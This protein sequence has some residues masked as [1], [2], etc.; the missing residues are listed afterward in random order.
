LIKKLAIA[1][2]SVTFS[3][4]S[5]AADQ[6]MD[7]MNT[8]AVTPPAHAKKHHK[9]MKKHHHKAIKKHHKVAQ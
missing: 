9:T 3:L 1:V 5:I 2:L 8:D 4:G 6:N 7:A